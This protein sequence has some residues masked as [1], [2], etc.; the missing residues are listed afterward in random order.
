[1]TILNAIRWVTAIAG[2]LAL[3]VPACIGA[4]ERQHPA[5]RA[6][7]LMK[8]LFLVYLGAPVLLFIFYRIDGDMAALRFNALGMIASVPLVC[9]AVAVH[10]WRSREA[11]G[12]Q[13]VATAQRTDGG[14]HS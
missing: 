12:V 5:Y 3:L 13:H 1:M 2:P 14:R 7:R 8:R 6:L 10:L 4:W 9:V 11:R